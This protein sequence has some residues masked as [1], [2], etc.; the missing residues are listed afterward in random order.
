MKHIVLCVGAAAWLLMGVAAGEGGQDAPESGERL[1]A[2]AQA[3]TE[4]R[5]ACEEDGG[6]LWGRPLWGPFMLV[7]PAT[8]RFVASDAI[9]RRG[10]G[11]A[12]P[13]RPVGAGD[14]EVHVGT[15]PGNMS[16]ANTASEYAGSRWAMALWPIPDTA[17]ARRQLLC[18]ELWHRIQPDLG[19]TLDNPPCDHLDEEQGRLWLRLEMRALAA[20]LRTTDASARRQ[21]VADAALFRA[22]RRSRYAAGA[23]AE[24]KLELTEGLAEYTGL[25]L[26]GRD[27][28]ASWA[29]ENLL[30]AEQQES[31]VRSFAYAT[32]PAYGLLLDEARPGWRKELAGQSELAAMLPSA[33]GLEQDAVEQ[34]PQAAIEEALTRYEGPALREQEGQRSQAREA[35]RRELTALLVDG[36]VLEV[37]MGKDGRVSFNPRNV[38]PLPPHGTVYPGATLTGPWGK[39]E[40]KQTQV[41]IASDWERAF[42]TAVGERRA[43]ADGRTISGAGWVLQLEP[44]WRLDDGGGRLRISTAD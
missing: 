37:P 12:A 1:A 20:A 18:H 39:L 44:G 28:Q 21:A 33:M 25:R 35:R 6:R 17:E 43:S 26:S 27:D 32:G 19:L 14:V 29:A 23:E 36:P 9:E 42:V 41:L 30:Q 11:A 2:A 15:L 40:A 7:D 5:K 38:L 13:T 10:A 24:R 34:A 3:F 4:A 31:L 8:R 16:V 22:Q